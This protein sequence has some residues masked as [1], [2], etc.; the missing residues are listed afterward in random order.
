MA[1]RSSTLGV[2][3][4]VFF[5]AGEVLG[6]ARFVP[7]MY[8][9]PQPVYNQAYATTQY[10]A[11]LCQAAEYDGLTAQLSVDLPFTAWSYDSQQIAYV[12]VTDQHGNVV[13]N[14]TEDTGSPIPDIEFVYSSSMGDLTVT[15]TTGNSPNVVFT[16]SIQFLSATFSMNHTSLKKRL[17]HASLASAQHTAV[18]DLAYPP[19]KV[20]PTGTV[21]QLTQIIAGTSTFQVP[22]DPYNVGILIDFDYCPMGQSYDV[23]VNVVALDEL[24]AFA[25]YLCVKASE[26]PCSAGNAQRANSDPSGTALNNV[27]LSTN[28]AEYTSL[29]A[30]IYG[31]GRYQGVNNAVLSVAVRPK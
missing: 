24:S 5:L 19:P 12:T 25:T 2:V 14:N 28:T 31:W 16:L 9:T 10:A 30:A 21:T 27:V 4:L 17:L 20:L 15:C 3:F 23:E 29:Q 18:S 6:A 26:M 1:M 22:T 11:S 13:K 8:V 7:F